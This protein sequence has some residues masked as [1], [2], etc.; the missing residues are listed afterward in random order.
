MTTESWVPD[1]CGLPTTEQP[2]RL[3]EFDALFATALRQVERPEPTRLHLRLTGPP[4]LAATLRDLTERESRCCS[5]FTFAV[6]DSPGEVVVDITVLP[7]YAEV[8]DALTHRALR[9]RPQ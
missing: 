7:A 1:A 9:Q 3:A 8:L 4:D 6:T 2:L 5:F